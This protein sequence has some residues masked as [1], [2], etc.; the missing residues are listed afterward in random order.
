VLAVSETRRCTGTTH[1][2]VIDIYELLKGRQCSA[3]MRSV[4]SSKPDIQ[5]LEPF[6]T[7]CRHSVQVPPPMWG[8]LRS[9]PRLHVRRA[10]GT[11]T[12][13]PVGQLDEAARQ[14]RENPWTRKKTVGGMYFIEAWPTAKSRYGQVQSSTRRRRFASW[15]SGREGMDPA[16]GPGAIADSYANR[17]ARGARK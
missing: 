15:N 10:G 3:S 6:A 1:V 16:Y 12:R 11:G 5:G 17:S 13:R 8:E 9:R 2:A 7:N 14:D 4:R